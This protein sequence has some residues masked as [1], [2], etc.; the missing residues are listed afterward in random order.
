MH[1]I[2]RAIT[3]RGGLA[4]TFELRADGFTRAQLGAAV[5]SREIVRVRHGW[6]V[7]RGIHPLLAQAARVGGRLTCVNGLALHG[8]WECPSE[9]LHVAVPPHACRLRDR[10]DARTR[11]ADEGNPLVRVHWR[12]EPPASRL[13]ST[14]GPIATRLLLDPIACL[15]HAI[16]CQPP[17]VVTAVADSLLRARPHLRVEWARLCERS[18]AAHRHFLRHVDGVCESGTE[19]LFWFR[20]RRFRLPLRR[21]VRIAGVGRVDFLIGEWLVIE[22]DGAAYHT[23]PARFEG[24]RHRDAVLSSIGYRVLRFSYRQVMSDWSEVE[25][26]VLAAVLRGDHF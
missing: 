6:Y 25:A 21:Q 26:A 17:E 5:A 16:G 14:V 18:P 1:P 3:S 13:P 9:E 7:S 19:S 15:E 2:S 4:A 10:N 11:L 23:D 8:A 12:A 24:D 22:V 20:M